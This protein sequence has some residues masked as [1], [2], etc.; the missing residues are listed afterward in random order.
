VDL[1]GYLYPGLA[2]CELAGVPDWSDLEHPWEILQEGENGLLAQ[3]SR[4]L[5]EDGVF[6]HESA[7]I[8]KFVHIEGPSFVGPNAEIRHSSYLRKGS[9]IC[10]GA[11]VG[12]SSEIKNS[13]LLPGAKAPHFNYV[14]DSILGFGSN[15]G[16]GVKLSNVRNDR[17]NVLV[18]VKDG[19]RID[20]G[21]YKMGALVG[22]GSQIGCNA[23][24]NP[25]TIIPPKSM[26]E[27]NK[28]VSGWF[29]FMS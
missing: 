26:V 2:E 15:L 20:S 18:T 11:L 21:S 4:I 23:V 1:L 7:K 24:T 16:A 8:G 10:E 28:T 13:I 27:P 9:W 19:S 3:I 5:G 14:G 17:R 22:D 12:H 29:G 6:I 25:G